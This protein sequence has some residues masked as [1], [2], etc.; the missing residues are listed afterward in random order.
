MRKF[1]GVNFQSGRAIGKQWTAYFS[2]C[3]RQF[4]IAGFGTP[5]EA[6]LA[7]DNGTYYTRN[8]AKRVV[9]FNF[10]T[11]WDGANVPPIHEK[12]AEA[13]KWLEENKPLA[14]G[15]ETKEEILNDSLKIDGFVMKTL[16]N[17]RSSLR[18]LGDALL[19]LSGHNRLMKAQN[20]TLE[21][22]VLKLTR[23]LDGLRNQGGLQVFK[24]VSGQTV[25]SNDVEQ[26]LG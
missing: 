7:A 4:Q 24:Q 17:M 25:P 20:E 19:T 3:K 14:S 9:A 2:V 10:P 23:S 8:W 5:E 12:V 16:T 6:A 13:V 22:E 1:R 15:Q 21:A 18:D 11:K 26:H